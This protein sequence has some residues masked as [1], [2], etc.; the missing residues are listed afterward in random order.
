M[1]RR[2]LNSIARD[3][4]RSNIY[5]T[6]ATHDKKPWASPV[7]YTM[8]QKGNFYYISPLTSVHTKNI[9]KNG[10]VSF[11]IFDSHQKEGTGNGIQGYG[12]ARLLKDTEL[13]KAF[14]VYRT[15]FIAM[16]PKSFTGK[17]LYR[18][19]KIIPRHLYIQDSEA[20]VDKRIEV[21]KTE[22]F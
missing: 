11:A 18:F 7:Y 5:M 3:I 1:N 10:Q 16:E 22:D 13:K 4:L 8:D 14:K 2:K 6:L 21:F 20:K 15:T 12:N 19:F 9:L 17:A